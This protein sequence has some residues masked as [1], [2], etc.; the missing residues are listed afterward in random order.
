MK[1]NA[2]LR[3]FKLAAFAIVIAL[4]VSIGPVQA[5]PYIVTLQQVGSNVVATGTGEIDLSGLTFSYFLSSGAFVDPSAGYIL[6]DAGGNLSSYTSVSGPAT[7]GTGTQTNVSSGS[8]DLV[9]VGG[10]QLFV[11]QGYVSD[12]VLSDS[13]T[14]N[15]ATLSSLGVTPGIYT[16][17]WG[18]GPNQSFTLD[19]VAPAV[20]DSG[21]TLALL[22]VALAG[23]FGASRLRCL[24]LA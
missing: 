22:A 21:S 8:G 17:T 23:F 5:N 2:S 11:P 9:G 7:F 6:T 15:S 24:R 13:S 10:S 3:A 1:T 14:Y 19:A 12:S 20:P 18:T 16:W 4:G